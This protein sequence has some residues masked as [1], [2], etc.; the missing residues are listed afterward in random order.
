MQAFLAWGLVG[1]AVLG[2][3]TGVVVAPK[4]ARTQLR[5]R[6]R[7][8]VRTLARRYAQ[9]RSAS[10][11]DAALAAD[12]LKDILGADARLRRRRIWVDA[13]RST[14]LLHGVVESHEEWRYAD[15]LARAVSPDGNVRNLVLIRRTKP[16]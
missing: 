7:A 10:R 12:R 5:S 8:N 15:R 1:A 6:A 9:W 2:S 14:L 3:V 4:P 13:H 16:E 11:V